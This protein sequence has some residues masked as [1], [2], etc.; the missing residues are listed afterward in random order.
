MLI[1]PSVKIGFG[2]ILDVT[3]AEFEEKINS[4]FPE[5]LRSMKQGF[6]PRSVIS[7]FAAKYPELS[8][9]ELKDSDGNFSQ[10]VVYASDRWQE[11]HGKTFEGREAKAGALYPEDVDRPEVKTF[12]KFMDDFGVS[13]LPKIVVWTR[14]V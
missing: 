8:V 10:V 5:R 2:F 12:Q 1:N 6:S 14:W 3:T 4:V 7:C 11:L 9:D 13:H